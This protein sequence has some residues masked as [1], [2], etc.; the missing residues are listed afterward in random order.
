MALSVRSV[1]PYAALTSIL[2]ALYASPLWTTYY[3]YDEGYMALD[4]PMPPYVA[5]FMLAKFGLFNGRP[6]SYFLWGFQIS[7][8]S[9]GHL[10]I[11]R[12]IVFAVGCISAGF[13][14]RVLRGRG[15]AGLVG[16]VIV[17]FLLSQPVFQ[18]YFAVSHRTTYWL[19]IVCSLWAYLHFQRGPLDRKRAIGSGLLL[20][21]GWT[22]FQATPFCA[23]A[24]LALDVVCADDAAWRAQR[25]RQA[26]FLGMFASVMLGYIVGYRL[27]LE[28]HTGPTYDKT[29]E[30]FAV[31]SGGGALIEA[32]SRGGSAAYLAPFEWWNYVWPVP[33]LE[34]ATWLAMTSVSGLV[35]LA[36][37]VAAWASTARGSSTAHERYGL[38]VILLLAT[39]MPVAADGFSARQNT[40]VAVVM[41]WVLLAAAWLRAL[42]AGSAP[43]CRRFVRISVAGLVVVVAAGARGG[44]ERALVG[45]SARCYES[46]VSQIREQVDSAYERI[47][48]VNAPTECPTEPCRGVFGA[49]RSLGAR[50]GLEAHYRS[51]VRQQGGRSDV[52]L[53]FRG[54]AGDTRDDR[55][56]LI[57]HRRWE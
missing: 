7:L 39:Y 6:T 46:T 17:A 54:D 37:L 55:A 57:D 38:V 53:T 42:A 11:L 29:G 27:L 18:I 21:V 31:L 3:I 51:L 40:H 56:M 48:V 23:L 26:R 9:Y 25:S 47:L 49:R 5:L 12:W 1:W 50:I 24:L 34:P 43:S 52:P 41:M 35:F 19:G 36:A 16:V 30:V 8:L 32:L 15:F 44:F 14:Y 10:A 22:T 20:L 45:P 4:E 33:R 28:L 2:F 13:L